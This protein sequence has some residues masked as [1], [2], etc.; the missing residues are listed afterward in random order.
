M[1]K[2]GV[3]V[4]VLTGAAVLAHA[5]AAVGQNAS[6]SL[7]SGVDTQAPSPGQAFRERSPSVVNTERAPARADQSANGSEWYGGAILL[8]D[9]LSIAGVFVGVSVVTSCFRIF[10]SGGN[11]AGCNLGAGLAFT[12]VVSLGITP[13]IIHLAHGN[14]AGAVMS[15]GLRALSVLL[16]AL[17]PAEGRRSVFGPTAMLALLVDAVFL[18]RRKV[19]QP[20]PGFAV[21]PSIFPIQAGGGLGLRGAF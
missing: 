19:E 4:S 7:L 20:T 1:A 9:G 17:A 13:A 2:L 14:G 3:V 21:R 15:V 8:S 10:G 5:S 18:A 12:S 11:G 16:T 6:P